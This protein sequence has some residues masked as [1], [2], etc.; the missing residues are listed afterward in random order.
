MKQ[1]LLNR[2]FSPGTGRIILSGS[3]EIVVPFRHLSVC[4]V[5][6]LFMQCGNAYDRPAVV[7]I[8]KNCL[9]REV[10]QIERSNHQMKYEVAIACTCPGTGHLP[11]CP[12]VNFFPAEKG[13]GKH[14]PH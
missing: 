3:F 6:L 7:E 4:I 13:S 5:L 12:A 2:S 8:C 14:G 1:N 9:P 11:G 10:R